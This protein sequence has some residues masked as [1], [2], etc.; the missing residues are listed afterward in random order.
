MFCCCRKPVKGSKT[1]HSTQA[2]G[3]FQ[4]PK[5]RIAKTEH[6]LINHSSMLQVI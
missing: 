3:E 5:V 1:H 6:E 2:G 4:L